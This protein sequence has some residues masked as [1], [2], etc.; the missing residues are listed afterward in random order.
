M[1]KFIWIVASIAVIIGLLAGSTVVLAK[2]D[3]GIA[4]STSVQAAGKFQTLVKL[5][6]VQDETKVND[7]LSQAV[8]NGKITQAQSDKLKTFWENNHARAANL[9][10][11]AIGKRLLSVQDGA[12]LNDFLNQ[13]VAAGKI[14]QDQ[15]N[16]IM[17]YW[18]NNHK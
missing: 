6:L 2:S 8:A 13:K 1:K 11:A 7:L 14:T 9:A 12:K 17:T 4:A 15:A 3:V 5:L 10:K 16:K 18:Q